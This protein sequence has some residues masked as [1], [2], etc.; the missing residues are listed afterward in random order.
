MVI[1][2]ASVDG[3]PCVKISDELMKASA[4]YDFSFGSLLMRR[5]PTQTEYRRGRGGKECE[6]IIRTAVMRDHVDIE[7]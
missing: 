3:N 2:L 7:L 5:S 1:K 6:D 4:V